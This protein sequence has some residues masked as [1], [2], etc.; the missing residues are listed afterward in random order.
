MERY[1]WAALQTVPG[2][3]NARL[4]NLVAFFGSA[5]QVWK[6]HRRDLFLCGC[7]DHGTCN[8]LLTQREK[9]DIHKCAEDWTQKGIHVL[10]LADGE[11]PSLLA[12]TCDPPT[13]LYYKG[14]LPALQPLIAIVGARRSSAYGQ[15]AAGMLA[16]ELADAGV[17]IVS[18]A[19][20]GID[21]A[22]HKGTLKQDGYTIAVLGCGVDICYPPEN[23]ILLADIAEKG[24][25]LS[26]YAPGT[27]PLPKFFPIRNRIISGLALG[28]VVVEAAEKSGSLITADFALE[29]GREVFAVPGSIFS[30]ASKG[31]HRLLK[32]GAKPVETAADILEEFR[33]TQPVKPVRTLPLLSG[34]QAAVL[35]T[36]SFDTPIGMDEIIVKSRLSPQVV[37]P[38]LVQLEIQGFVAQYS[39]QR[40]VRIPGRESVE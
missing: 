22:A 12:K 18:G 30:A 27:A 8:N 17:G 25:V 24:L 34:D 13:V 28:V 14:R 23:A 7:L 10:S 6:A 19:A 1:F 3:G 11:Y 38:M 33:F 15:N 32:Q 4:K 5:E 35:L 16:A 26:E 36:L 31:T 37:V 20:R 29:E 40:F 39:G 21:T 9:I 2:L